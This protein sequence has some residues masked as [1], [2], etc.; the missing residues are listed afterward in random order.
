MITSAVT[1]LF[2]ALFALALLSAA[3][4]TLLE[5]SA[6]WVG[7]NTV[8][9]PHNIAQQLRNHAWDSNASVLATIGFAV[10]GII[11]LFVAMRG[12]RPLTL[13]CRFAGDTHVERRSLERTIT[14]QLEALDGIQQARVRITNKR[15]DA[16]VVSHRQ[17]E[18]D[19]LSNVA[20]AHISTWIER[21]GISP[22]IHVSLNR[23]P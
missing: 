11:A 5:I 20:Q 17:Y 7:N 22:T 8:V 23:S 4:V 9:L 6:G 1:R 14:R 3:I 13:P 18:R 16:M 10:L 19:T 15:L 12:T 2:S 21:Y